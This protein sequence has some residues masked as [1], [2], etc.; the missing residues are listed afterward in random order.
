MPTNPKEAFQVPLGRHL[1]EGAVHAFPSF[2]KRL[3]NL[4]TRVLGDRL[5]SVTVDRPIYV[6]G[7][8]RSG[9][10]ILLEALATHTDT[11]THQYRD[12]P[13]I[14]TPFWWHAFLSRVPGNGVTPIERAHGDGLM[15][16][17]DSPEAM[18]EAIWMA[19][20]PHAH[21]HRHSHVLAASDSH[22]D[23]EQF[24]SNH[25]RK[26]LLVHQCGRYVSKG[27][28]NLTRLHYLLRMFPDA[29]VVIPI[30]RPLNHIAS[31]MKQHRIF[32]EGGTHH[33]RAR[34]Q[35]RRVGHYEFGLDRH[36]I[37]TGDPLA[38]NEIHELWNAGEEVRGWARYWAQIYG[39]VADQ[40]DQV[41]EF[42]ESTIV[43]RFEDLCDDP[44]QVLER[45]FQHAELRDDELI[46]QFA[47]K[48][49]APGY[50]RP[51]FTDEERTI[52]AEETDAV[53]SRFGYCRDEGTA[54]ASVSEPLAASNA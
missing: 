42:K 31:L 19:F 54:A 23:F 10:T 17:P 6:A 14:F 40:L 28:Y 21:D 15:I 37:N 9:S 43:V 30:R 32:T 20:F 26:L 25:L 41:A 18:E 45:L 47:D 52:I 29:R 13:G 44:Q 3:G 38:T 24:Y 8:A 35:M 53:A 34:V 36:A 4:E 16:T 50:Y 7:L 49:H 51:S 33:P 1:L 5:R 48:V 22:P 39:W 12:F 46:R 11:A 2:W 27:N